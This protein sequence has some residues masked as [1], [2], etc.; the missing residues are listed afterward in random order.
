M[1]G[2]SLEKE[3]KKLHEFVENVKKTTG[4]PIIPDVKSGAALW[5]D[6]RE[7]T[8]RYVISV[9]KIRKFYEGLMDNKLYATKCKSCNR[10]YFPPQVYCPKCINGNIEWVELSREGELLT[11][12]IIYVKP[13]S[14]THYHD[15]AVGVAR[16]KEGIN[17]TAWIR[18]NDPR[19]LRVGMKVKIEIVR[20]EPEGYLTYEIVPY[21][22]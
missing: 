7:I 18:E 13:A 10:L 17:I 15:Y 2:K 3:F 5:Y 21:E 1:V 22:S 19:K 6:Q 20:R 12:T 14:F 9:D 16:L 4:L 11:Y 8:V